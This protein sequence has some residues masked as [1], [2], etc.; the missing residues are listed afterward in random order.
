MANLIDADTLAE[1]AIVLHDVLTRA[2]LPHVFMGGF[3][4]LLHG[5]PR[6]SKDIDV[7]INKPIAL[8]DHGSFFVFDGNRK[9]AVRLPFLPFLDRRSL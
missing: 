1:A 6:G 5:S 4:L 3:Q 8:K 7:E 9:D 2:N